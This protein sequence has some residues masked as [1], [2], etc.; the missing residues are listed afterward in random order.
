MDSAGITRLGQTR[1]A[2]A[3]ASVDARQAAFSRSLQPLLGKTLQGEVLSKLTD[4]SYLVKVAGTSARMMLPDGTLPGRQVALTLVAVDPRPTFQLGADAKTGAPAALLYPEV[5]LS[6]EEL[7]AG[8]DELAG[9][10]AHA[11]G[12]ADGTAAARPQSL[13]A[14]LLGKAPLIPADQLPG[15]DPS[16]PAPALSSAARAI[17]TVLTQAQSQPGTPLAIE[18]RTPLLAAAAGGAVDTAQLSRNLHEAVGG[19]G[20]FYESHIVDWAQGTRTLADLTREPQM[21]MAA[22]P[23][24]TAARASADLASAQMV[25]LQLHTQ[26]QGQVRWQGQAW[27]GQDMEWDVSKQQ[28]DGKGNDKENAGTWRSGLRF[29]FPG[30]GEVAA[31]LVLVNGQVH[32]QMQTGN[33]TSTAALRAGVGELE[34][35]LGAAGSPLSSFSVGTQQAD[36]DGR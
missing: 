34:L 18:G 16:A 22:T 23:A 2:S 20:L 28:P 32:L 27:A 3:D 11:A 25:N 14:R 19:S 15:F 13:A 36:N 29:R 21:Q 5:M 35:A 10:A 12:D 26:E 17:S 30:L 7:P 4:G 9:A 6:G 24:N 31:S 33:E 1:A 8:A